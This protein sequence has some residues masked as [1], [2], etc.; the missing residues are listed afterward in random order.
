MHLK[1]IPCM[2]ECDPCDRDVAPM[3]REEITEFNT[4]YNSRYNKRHHRIYFHGLTAE[5]KI[6]RPATRA[7]DGDL[8]DPLD[9]CVDGDPEGVV[10]DV[11]HNAAV[12]LIVLKQDNKVIFTLPEPLLVYPCDEEYLSDNVNDALEVFSNAI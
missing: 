10:V 4:N 8:L 3:L 2:A 7:L 12:C 9:W 1:S 11:L 5:I 6:L